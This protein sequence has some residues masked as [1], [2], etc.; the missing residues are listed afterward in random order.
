MRERGK[1]LNGVAALL[2]YSEPIGHTVE[3]PLSHE[4][5]LAFGEAQRVQKTFLARQIE[6]L[7][8]SNN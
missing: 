1:L 6:P 8:P 7:K 3:V 4:V 2:P 5:Q